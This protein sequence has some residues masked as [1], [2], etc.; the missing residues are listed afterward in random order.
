MATIVLG[1]IREQLVN[2][3]PPRAVFCDFPLGRPL[4]KPGDAAFQHRV[5]ARGFSL[6]ERSQ[7]TVE[8]FPERLA[9]QG[10]EILVCSLPPR[11]D[12]DAHPAVDEARGLRAAY[13]R[14]VAEHGNRVAASR[15][16][17][18]DDIPG[19]LEAFIRIAQGTPWK[20]AKIP[21]IP[22]RVAQDI[23]GYYETAALAIVDHTPAAWAST[24]WYRDS[25]KAGEVVRSAQLAMKNAGVRRD[26]WAFLLPMDSI[27]MD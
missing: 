18:P 20:E 25:T 7:R 9:D 4:G 16:V 19:A 23:R 11:Y 22:A 15:T 8:D 12:P 27:P 21:G 1:S 3:A 6:L 13:D 5:L 14:A 2:T 10:S 24:R 17:R 26:L